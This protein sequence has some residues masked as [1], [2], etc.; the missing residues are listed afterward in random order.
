MSNRKHNRECNKNRY[1]K[2]TR[3]NEDEIKNEVF[4]LDDLAVLT[5]A[6]I[7]LS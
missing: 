2:H 1:A 3:L 6:L 4:F 5:Q 7:W